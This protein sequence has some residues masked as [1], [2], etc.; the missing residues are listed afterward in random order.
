MILA[1]PKNPAPKDDCVRVENLLVLVHALVA[2]GTK[3]DVDTAKMCY[4]ELA[5]PSKFTAFATRW[6]YSICATEREREKCRD[7]WYFCRQCYN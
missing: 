6:I 2:M 5:S 7:K 4:I 1:L 3:S